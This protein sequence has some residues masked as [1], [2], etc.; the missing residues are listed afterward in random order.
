M[1]ISKKLTF[2]NIFIFLFL[3]IFPLGQIIRIGILQPIDVIAGMGGLYALLRKQKKPDV[4]V[5]FE[6]FLAV[7]L[8]SWVFS[9]FIFKDTNVFYGL[10]Y[11]LRLSGYFYF[12]I[13]VWNFVIKENINAK[14]IQDSL[15]AVSAA[16]ALFGWIQFFLIPDIKPFFTWGWDMHLF[17]LVGTFLD[18][19][20]LGLIIVFGLI[21]ALYRCVNKMNFK[22]ISL[23]GF[24]LVSLAFTYS[25]AS[26]LAFGA[27]VLGIIYFQKN[28]K[29]LLFLVL[30]LAAIALILPTS[31]NHSIEL[32]RTFSAIARVE[33]YQ[34]T[35]KIFANSPV[36]GLGYDNLCI[37]YQK[38]IGPQSFG[39]H[40]CSGS[41]SSLLF[42]L[43]TTG[44][45]GLILFIGLI[46]GLVGN[47]NTKSARLFVVSGV[48][49]LIHS[50]FSNS[51]F[52]PWILGYLILLL[53][54]GLRRKS[55]GQILLG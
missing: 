29:K 17:R 21:Q 10:L 20:F 28:L 9:I 4:F 3:A 1:G 13:Y 2:D 51:L 44:A 37:A 54:M 24:F 53:S 40:A 19:S 27:A 35:L 25:R 39:S 43:A 50:I 6:R 22:N 38:F 47:L 49:V 5:Y 16:S 52:Y 23:A 55:N 42:I 34:T 11:F 12:F 31:K 8:F 45:A 33:N 36:F 15:L 41:D 48:A 32:F 26:Y 18:P 14:L 46:V 30:G 7:A